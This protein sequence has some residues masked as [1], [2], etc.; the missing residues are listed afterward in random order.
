MDQQER[1]LSALASAI[2]HDLPL[3][4]YLRSFDQGDAT[5]HYVE[6][7]ETLSRVLGNCVIVPINDP[8]SDFT[9]RSVPLGGLLVRNHDWRDLVDGLIPLARVVVIGV[10]RSSE[11]IA[12]ELQWLKKHDAVK[13]SVLIAHGSFDP[14][15][16]ET[17]LSAESVRAALYH[18]GWN[19]NKFLLALIPLAAEPWC[20]SIPRRRNR[21]KVALAHSASSVLPR[22]YLYGWRDLL[23]PRDVISRYLIGRRAYA[24]FDATGSIRRSLLEAEERAYTSREQ[25]PPSG[26]EFDDSGPLSDELRRWNENKRLRTRM[27]DAA[28]VLETRALWSEVRRG[29]RKPESASFIVAHASE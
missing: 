6:M 1:L 11:G 13:K 24:H 15:E 23:C 22:L 16:F 17:E 4:L 12:Q 10:S 8:G 2:E 28:L 25:I 27:E 19:A 9:E 21:V 26:M 5:E 20:R 29:I 18:G 7:E 14:K 3:V